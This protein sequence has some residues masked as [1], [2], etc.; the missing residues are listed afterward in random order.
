M[1]RKVNM[2]ALK[3]SMPYLQKLQAECS[4]Q[5]FHDVLS[6]AGT[7][8]PVYQEEPQVSSSYWNIEHKI[9]ST[10]L[11]SSYCLFV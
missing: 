5:V 2:P 10:L 9:L 11:S 4:L 7:G 6:S 8:Q 1:N 3:Q